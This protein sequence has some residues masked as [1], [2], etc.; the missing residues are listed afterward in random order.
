MRTGSSSMHEYLRNVEGI[1]MSTIK[2]PNFFLEKIGPL[3]GWMT[4]H[5][6]DEKKYLSLFQPKKDEMVLGESSVAYLYDSEAAY[7]IN[8]K[9]ADAKILIILRDPISRAYSHFLHHVHLGFEHTFNFFEAIQIDNRIEKR[10]I[11]FAHLYVDLG[12]YTN[13]VERYFDLFGRDRVKVIIYEDEFKSKTRET[14]Q[15]VVHFLGLKSAVDN[16]VTQ[17]FFGSPSELTPGSY[18]VPRYRSVSKMSKVVNEIRRNNLILTKL[19]YPLTAAIRKNFLEQIRE[20]PALSDQARLYLQ[21]LYRDDV[22]NL[23]KI[24]PREPSWSA[25]YRN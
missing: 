23:C 7:R 10:G 20:K 17:K 4:Y 22:H 24:L 25:K 11:G 6:K 8:A 18:A 14:V 15:D 21:D 16:K 13:Q 2:E 12:K 19:T 5:I 9:I 1:C 3:Y